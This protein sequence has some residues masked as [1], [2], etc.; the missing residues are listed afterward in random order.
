MIPATAGRWPARGRGLDTSASQQRGQIVHAEQG[1]VGSLRQPPL[2]EPDDPLQQVRV[3]LGPPGHL[4]AHPGL[5][6]SATALQTAPPLTPPGPSPYPPVVV[7]ARLA[8]LHRHLDGSLRPATLAELAARAGVEVPADLA[9]FPGMGLQEA[10]ARF[11]LTLS[12]LQEPAAVRRVAAEMCEDAAGEGVTTLEV[13]F[14]P[15]LHRGGAPEAVVDAALDGIGGRAGLVLCGLY[16]EPPEVLE[17]LVRIG[18]GR[19]GVVGIDLAGGPA[20]DQAFGMPDYAA[21][22][23]HAR[24]AGLGRTVHAGEGRPAAEIRTAIET[25]HAQRI[26]HGTSLLDDPEVLDVVL[27]RG[28][29]VEACATSNWHVGVIGEVAEHPFPRWLDL[30]V[31]ACI[32]TDNTLLSAVDAPQEHRRVLAI[33]GMDA[34]R[35]VR[36]VRY[37][38]EAAFR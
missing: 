21:A 6:D 32:N 31:R 35:L 12:V 27:E 38:H 19:P 26:G 8:D 10:L 1:R 24:D 34:P 17:R 5:V 15:Q 11:R 23:T 30:G 28:V 20:A 36:A 22:F 18:A 13:R 4:A 33:P 9:F 3:L 29:T 2:V 25:L 7:P 37:G 16:G 14:A